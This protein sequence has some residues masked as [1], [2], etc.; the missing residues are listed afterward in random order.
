MKQGT[1]LRDVSVV[2]EQYWCLLG[3]ERKGKE[4]YYKHAGVGRTNREAT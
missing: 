1:E 4:R 3:M 2:Y